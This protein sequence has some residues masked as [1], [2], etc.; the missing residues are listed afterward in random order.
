MAL[1]S[2]YSYTNGSF[3]SFL[4]PIRYTKTIL[5]IGKSAKGTFSYFYVKLVGFHNIAYIHALYLPL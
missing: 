1:Y 2:M 4:S 3:L 5:V